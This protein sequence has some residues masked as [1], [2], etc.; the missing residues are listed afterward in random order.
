MVEEMAKERKTPQRTRTSYAS[1]TA[2]S[3][4]GTDEKSYAASSRAR[5]EE[6][7]YAT[8]SGAGIEK[9]ESSS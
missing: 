4:A 1:Y 3:G 8:A 6:Q 5:T 2:A 9:I 7:S